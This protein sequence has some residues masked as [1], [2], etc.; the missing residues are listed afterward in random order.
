M[1]QDSSKDYYTALH[2]KSL[3]KT[4]TLDSDILNVSNKH[5]PDKTVMEGFEATHVVT[6][7]TY[8]G[9]AHFIFKDVRI[10]F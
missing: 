8:G 10:C 9:D 3:T 6:S 7:I 1:L 2:Y 5:C 4:E